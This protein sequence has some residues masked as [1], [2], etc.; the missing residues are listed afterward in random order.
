[1]Q[2]YK[3]YHTKTKWLKMNESTLS[4][5]KIPFSFNDVSSLISISSYTLLKNNN[6]KFNVFNVEKMCEFTPFL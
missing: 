1:M 3:F 5:I 2:D 4:C 6:I